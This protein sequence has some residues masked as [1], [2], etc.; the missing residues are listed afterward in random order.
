MPRPVQKQNLRTTFLR[1]GQR[2]VKSKQRSLLNIQRQ[3]TSHRPPPYS[4]FDTDVHEETGDAYEKKGDVYD[5]KGAVHEGTGDVHEQRGTNYLYEVNYR[6]GATNFNHDL[7][8]RDVS[9]QILISNSLG[10]R[11]RIDV[12]YRLIGMA[13]TLVSVHVAVRR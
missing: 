1:D 4:P 3:Q 8:C 9:H 11:Y 13:E 5:R 12:Q 10:P 6:L 7:D 2:R